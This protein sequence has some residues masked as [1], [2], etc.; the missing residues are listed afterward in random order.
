[1]RFE[2]KI[3]M[4]FNLKEPTLNVV[5]YSKTDEEHHVDGCQSGI[6]NCA[7]AIPE[8]RKEFIRMIGLAVNSCLRIYEGSKQ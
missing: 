4:P 1:M 5:L 7:A 2:I 8:D 3:N 6:F